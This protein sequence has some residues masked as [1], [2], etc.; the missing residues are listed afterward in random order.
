M[1]FEDCPRCGSWSLIVEA[2]RDRLL[3]GVQLRAFCTSCEFKW[4]PEDTENAIG[5]TGVA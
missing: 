1:T 5:Q 3:E 2:F 4:T